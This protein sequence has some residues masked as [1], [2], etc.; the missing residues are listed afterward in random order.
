M[1]HI[2]TEEIQAILESVQTT[3]GSSEL[4][5]TSQEEDNERIEHVGE[6]IVVHGSYADSVNQSVVDKMRKLD[7]F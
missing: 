4:S 2:T 3:N 5:A 7:H 1:L 6:T